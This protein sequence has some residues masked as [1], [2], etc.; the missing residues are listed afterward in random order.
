VATP[1]TA[2]KKIIYKYL[3]QDNDGLLSLRSADEDLHVSGRLCASTKPVPDKKKVALVSLTTSPDYAKSDA[4]QRFD[5]I[6]QTG[7][8][9]HVVGTVKWRGLVVAKKRVLVLNTTKTLSPESKVPA[10][11]TDSRKTNAVDVSTTVKKKIGG[12]KPDK[13]TLLEK[14]KVRVSSLIKLGHD[15]E[16]RMQYAAYF[17]GQSPGNLYKKISAGTF[18]APLKKGGGSFWKHSTLVAYQNNT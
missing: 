5:V 3:G 11:D 6:T 8:K 14:E 2:K 4:D 9:L 1:A 18:P 7:E 15:P 10:A 13:D 16:V 17:V 12:I